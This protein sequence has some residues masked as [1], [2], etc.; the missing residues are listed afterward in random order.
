[1]KK[2]VLII[3]D[4]YVIRRSLEA[5]LCANDFDVLLAED[6]LDGV[7]KISTNS[8][9]QLVI[10]DVNMPRMGGLK[11][12]KWLRGRET[13]KDLPFLLLTAEKKPEM[14]REARDDGASGWLVKPFQSETLVKTIAKM[15]A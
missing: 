15:I 9:I 11:M 5:L 4:S 2:T 8:N 6:G 13:T 10:C 3:D 7:E 14:I 12:L 1:M